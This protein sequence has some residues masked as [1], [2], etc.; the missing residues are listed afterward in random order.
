MRR[1]STPMTRSAPLRAL[2]VHTA[3]GKS[4]TW[5]HARPVVKPRYTA[6]KLGIRMELAA[7]EP[8]LARRIDLMLL[9]GALEEA[10]TA[11]KSCPDHDAPG[12]S[13]IGCVELL[14]Y[15]RGEYGLER[16]R[17]LWFRNTRAYAKRQLTWFRK[18]EDM[19]W[20]PPGEVEPALSLVR[21][22]W[23]QGA[24]G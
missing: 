3:T 22:F 13:S 20:I 21:S 9:A 16:A 2:E 7:L 15:L 6:L 24:E 18:D 8:L 1:R 12:W 17:E 14:G 4:L 23:E 5:W 10:E 11:W 19:H